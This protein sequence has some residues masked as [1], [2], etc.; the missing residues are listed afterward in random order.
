M[1]PRNMKRVRPDG[2]AQC[3]IHFYRSVRP[4]AAANIATQRVDNARFQPG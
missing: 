1:Q 2:T 4:P 3:A